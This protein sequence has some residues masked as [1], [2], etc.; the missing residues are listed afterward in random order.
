MQGLEIIQSLSQNLKNIQV[1][2]FEHIQCMFSMVTRVRTWANITSILMSDILG[3]QYK[4]GM[5]Q[6]SPTQSDHKSRG[7]FM[8]KLQSMLNV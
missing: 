6:M 4:V 1:Y 7:Y 5:V 2:R 8:E 3:A